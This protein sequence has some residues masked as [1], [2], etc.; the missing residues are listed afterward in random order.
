MAITTKMSSQDFLLSNAHTI[1]C[2]WN[3]TDP[4]NWKFVRNNGSWF[5]PKVICRIESSDANV[6]LLIEVS[7]VVYCFFIGLRIT[8]QGVG[9]RDRQSTVSAITDFKTGSS[10]YVA[11]ARIIIWRQLT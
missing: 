1:N 5:N 11:Y 8:A 7:D 9:T 3:T 4:N 10:H 2:V 6:G